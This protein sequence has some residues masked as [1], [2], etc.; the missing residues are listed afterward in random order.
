MLP[1]GSFSFDLGGKSEAKCSIRNYV[2]AVSLS[3]GRNADGERLMVRKIALHRVMSM[4]EIRS[5]Q[6]MQSTYVFEGGTP[7]ALLL[8]HRQLVDFF[9]CFIDA[10][11]F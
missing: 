9:S 6:Q 3:K 10:K 8:M 7:S 4:V 11:S 1:T 2:E 5:Q